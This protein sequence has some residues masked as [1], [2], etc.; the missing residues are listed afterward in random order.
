MEPAPDGLINVL[1]PGESAIHAEMADTRREAV[2]LRPQLLTIKIQPRLFLF[3]GRGGLARRGLGAGDG[4]GAT[5][6]RIND[7][8]RRDLQSAF[9]APGTAIEEVAEAKRL[10]PAFGDEGR[11]LRGD[12]LRA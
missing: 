6:L 7:G 5:T 12:Q 3:G 9:G 11:I 8:E 2:M 1:L 4:E 10:L